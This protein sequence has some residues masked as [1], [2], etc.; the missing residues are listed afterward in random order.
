[1]HLNV[2]TIAPV[3]EKQRNP[4]RFSLFLKAIGVFEAP[5]SGGGL[6]IPGIFLLMTLK[7]VLP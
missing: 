1:M 7:I 2:Q 6:G 4:E 5:L 3:K